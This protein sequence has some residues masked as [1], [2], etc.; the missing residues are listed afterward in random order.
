MQK[1]IFSK[2]NIILSVFLFGAIVLSMIN[3]TEGATPNPG[4][5]ASEVDFVQTTKT[6][7]YTITTTDKVIMADAT[8]GAFTLTLPS[9]VG[10]QDTLFFIKK[11]DSALNNI[12]TIAT[13]SS[14]T[15]DSVS[16]A[17]LKQ[18]GESINLQS[19]GTNWIV[20]ARQTYNISGFRTKGST[21]NQWYTSPNTGTYFTTGSPAINT[22][23]VTPFIVSKTTTIDQMA[24]NVTTLGAG[25][26][27]RVGIY[28]DDGNNYPG[29]LV[30]DA[31]TQ[32]GAST[33]VKTYT[34][35][36]PVTLEPGLYWL[37]YIV[38]GTA[39]AI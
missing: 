6:A 17:T 4:H 10:I 32:S 31:G 19:N 21:L 22:I 35:N 18:R 30:V 29:S 36:L 24:I 8:S 33:G 13:Q 38:N 9:A 28:A 7:N 26:T 37:A 14:Q 23:N 11:I 2:L 1:N 27:P 12:V 15:I 25:S 39:P 5:A 34:T 3:V 16:Q 20:L